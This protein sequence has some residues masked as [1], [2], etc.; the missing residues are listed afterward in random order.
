[1]SIPLV[2]LIVAQLGGRLGK[3]V[4]NSFSTKIHNIYRWINSDT[5]LKWLR[6]DKGKFVSFRVVKIHKHTNISSWR[7]VPKKL[8]V[9][10]IATKWRSENGVIR[11]KTRISN[12]EPIILP[13]SHKVSHLIT[14]Q[15]QVKRI[16]K[17]LEAMENNHARPPGKMM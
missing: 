2:K 10:D 9:D 17:K 7:Y 1:M 11:S 16:I 13:R 14:Q 5:V 12:Y 8:N 3:T 15:Q 4:V 6:A